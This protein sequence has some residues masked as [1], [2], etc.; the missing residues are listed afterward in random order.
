MRFLCY[1]SNLYVNLQS[2]I[3]SNQGLVRLRVTVTGSSGCVG[4]REGGAMRG[5]RGDSLI[6]GGKNGALGSSNK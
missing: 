3:E 1:S 2:N 4:S 6:S 5:R